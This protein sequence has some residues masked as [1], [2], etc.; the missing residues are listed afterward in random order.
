MMDQVRKMQ[1]DV[2]RLVRQA[3]IANRR[4]DGF[5][6][7]LAEARAEKQKKIADEEGIDSQMENV[8]NQ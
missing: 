3:G 2:A 5:L 1:I 8:E 6:L 7:E 4:W